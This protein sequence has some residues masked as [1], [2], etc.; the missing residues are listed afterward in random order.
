MCC[1]S[2]PE[3]A[4]TKKAMSGAK[5]GRPK[6]LAIDGEKVRALRGGASQETFRRCCKISTDRLQKAERGSATEQT[7][8]TICKYAAKKGHNLTT[9]DLKIK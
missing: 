3:P 7:I 6:A 5:G 2:P 4:A 1:A 9:D 8:L